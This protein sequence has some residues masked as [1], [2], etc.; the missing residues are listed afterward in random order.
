MNTGDNGR[1]APNNPNRFTLNMMK[2]IIA[3]TPSIVNATVPRKRSDRRIIILITANIPDCILAQ[4]VD[5]ESHRQ[6]R[7]R[8]ARRD[9]A[10]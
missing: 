3:A 1:L 10:R 5:Q 6:R 4:Q 2:K 7:E 9:L 8:E